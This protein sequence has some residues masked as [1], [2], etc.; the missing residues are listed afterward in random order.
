MDKHAFVK[1]IGK[2]IEP[3][4]PGLFVLSAGR[5]HWMRVYIHNTIYCDDMVLKL[6]SEWYKKLIVLFSLLCDED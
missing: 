3:V 1:A 6:I 2:L 5:R 4:V